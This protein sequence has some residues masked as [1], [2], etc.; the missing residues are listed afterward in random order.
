MTWRI[1]ITAASEPD[2]QALSEDDREALVEELFAW[3]E[4]GPTRSEPRLVGGAVIFS[5]PLVCGY[6]VSYFVEETDRYV[7]IVR[8]RPSR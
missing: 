2:F 8:L 6:T 3:I 4:S 1:L 7:A 5:D